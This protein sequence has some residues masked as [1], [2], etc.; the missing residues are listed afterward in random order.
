MTRWSERTGFSREPN[1]L[2]GK[3]ARMRAR[4]TEIV[5][6]TES[7]PTR[8]GFAAPE[9]VALLGDARGALYQPDPLGR[10]ETRAAVAAYYAR[11]GMTVDP[12]RIVLTASTSEAYGWLFKLLCNPGEAVF[13]PSTSYP[14]FSYLAGLESVSLC[15]SPSPETRAVL[16]VHPT[17]PTGCYVRD[18]DALVSTAREGDMAL[19]VD[20]VFWDYAH[21][22]VAPESFVTE[23]R[24]LTFVLSGLSKVALLPQVKLGWIVVGG[25]ESDVAEALGRL[26][27]IADSYLSVSTP[28]QIAAPAMLAA[29]DERQ[30]ALA[31]RLSE[32]IAAIDRALREP[33]RR[34][35]IEGGWYAI[36]EVPRT[37]SDEAWVE[38][39]LEAERVLVHPGYF[40]DM[41]E[42]GRMVVSLLPEPHVFADAI[43]RS[44]ACWLSDLA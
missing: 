24:V 39:L 44:V 20:E 40:F 18:R 42:A 3:L 36:I 14:L 26:E 13:A 21:A 6:L 11:R 34:L 19:V 1:W 2:S 9:L 35:P 27:L 30:R 37:R 43:E 29:A 23:A 7:N 25:P 12:Q 32:N 17:N 8:C 31:A 15:A 22:H 28:V 5:D 41:D 16:L 38:H 10:A 33:L 4:G